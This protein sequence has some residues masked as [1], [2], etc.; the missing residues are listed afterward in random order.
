[1]LLLELLEHPF[2]DP[3][4][5]PTAETH[6]DGVPVPEPFRH[7][8]PFA[9]LLQYVQHPVQSIDVGYLDVSSLF[10][11]R[12]CYQMVLFMCYFHMVMISHQCHL[13]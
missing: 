10:R 4:V 1:M 5:R 13:A 6:V 3:V 9:A 2:E 12:V 7:R 8:T 11:E